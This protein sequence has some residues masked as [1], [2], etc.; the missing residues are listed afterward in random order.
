MDKTPSTGDL[1]PRMYKPKPRS[2][3][4]FDIGAAFDILLET[5]NRVYVIPPKDLHWKVLK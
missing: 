1:N 4:D 5:K 3:K 2:G